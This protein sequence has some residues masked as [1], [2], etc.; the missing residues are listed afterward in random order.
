MQV[1]RSWFVLPVALTL[2]SLSS[3]SAANA[4]VAADSPQVIRFHGG[5][6]DR[7]GGIAVDAAND[8]YLAGSADT[9]GA[10]SFAVV[11]VSAEGNLLW[12]TTYSGAL[13]GVGGQALAVTV[14]PNG[15]VYAA[16][17]IT[18]GVIFNTNYDYLV[19]KLGSDG[20]ERWARRYNGPGNGFDQAT[21]LAVDPSGAVTVS[22]FSEGLGFDWATLRYGSD[23]TLQWTRRHSGPGSAD[24][25]VSDLALAPDGNLIVTGFT[26]NTGDGLTNDIDT[27]T[28]DP[29]GNIVWRRTWSATAT[30]HEDA[31]DMDV[32]ASGR[33]VLTG[34][35]AENPSPYAVPSPIT[36]RY[37]AQGALL[38]T[39]Q[40]EGAGGDAVDVDTAGNFYVAGSLVGTPGGSTTARYDVAGARS[41]ATPLALDSS[42]AML[43]TAVAV[44]S[45][46]AITVAGTVIDVFN[47]NSDYLTIRYAADGRE[48]WRHRFNGTGDREDRVAGL[49][50]DG[51]DAALVTGTSWS[52]YLSIG[53]TAD[54]IVT[55]K[56]PTGLVP[57]LSAPSHLTASTVSASQIQLRW[58]D[59]A[60]T[61][62][63]FRIERCQGVGCTSFAQVAVVG[64]DVTAYF[65]GALTRN[66]SYTYRVQAINATANSPYSNPAT[67]KT[68]RK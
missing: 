57:P 54:D 32:D 47:H 68:R 21:K 1:S 36:L 29:Q 6:Y 55:L 33:I 45:A 50:V 12:R 37:D 30:S 46:G 19:V 16:G 67:A 51:T 44:G 26:K 7:A 23:G 63:G 38:Q 5:A 61:E 49:A 62:T 28:Y 11:K 42:D 41:W 3:A 8:I 18:D 52:D 64:R 43:V 13:G 31:R 56:F 4:A 34:T 20:L 2:V 40:G 24:D 53:G 22:G 25:R 48:L 17:Y 65:D 66:T 9:G 27:L 35:T 59:N 14:D 15:N 39:I 58:H 10:I 60:G